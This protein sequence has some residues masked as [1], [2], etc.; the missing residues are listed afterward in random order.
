[1]VIYLNLLRDLWPTKNGQEV[2]SKN[3]ISTFDLKMSRAFAGA[4][5]VSPLLKAKEQESWRS[6]GQTWIELLDKTVLVLLPYCTRSKCIY[7]VRYMSPWESIYLIN[8]LN[9]QTSPLPSEQ[10]QGGSAGCIRGHRPTP[11]PP[12]KEQSSGRWT[13]PLWHRTHPRSGCRPRPH[14]DQGPGHWWDS[15]VSIA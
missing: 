13:L 15:G 12:A 8:V 3:M 10:C 4:G 1:M 5:F 2:W 14:W 9:K 6:N 11:L 7:L